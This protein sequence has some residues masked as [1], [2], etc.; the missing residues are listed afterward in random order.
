L[1]TLLRG[2]RIGHAH[3]G[4]QVHA[5]RDLVAREQL[6]ARHF[7]RLHAQLDELDGDV[8][9][10][11]PEGVAAGVQGAHQLAV[12]VEQAGGLVGHG[13]G[14][15][16]AIEQADL[17]QALR[18]LAAQLQ[19]RRQGH[20][21]DLDRHQALPVQLARARCEQVL[22]LAVLHHQADLIDADVGQHEGF[23]QTRAQRG[24]QHIGVLAGVLRLGDVVQHDLGAAQPVA[25]AVDARSEHALET[26]VAVDQGAL[27]VAD[28]DPLVPEHDAFSLVLCGFR[29]GRKGRRAT[30]SFVARCVD[31]AAAHTSGDRETEWGGS[32]PHG[33][34][35]EPVRA[36][37]GVRRGTGARRCSVT[38]G[39]PLR[40]VA[41]RA[42]VRRR[43]RCGVPSSAAPER[44][45]VRNA[46]RGVSGWGLA[47]P[48]SLTA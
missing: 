30:G 32:A 2:D 46:A 16:D 35:A 28:H 7:H 5:Q 38:S 37:R 4:R 36:R 15:G 44:G 12:D 47:S 13:D 9:L 21:D 24:H 33:V 11:V 29:S 19:P 40:S 3:A 18:D 31:A 6:L 41:L 25:D 14:H 45:F 10:E 20:G 43:R 39:Q 42:R 27:G 22:E 1:A 23:A 17:A 8:L 48:V 34:G 26:A